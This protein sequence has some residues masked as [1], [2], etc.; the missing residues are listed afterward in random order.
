MHE[1][2]IPLSPQQPD[3]QAPGDSQPLTTIAPLW[4]TTLVI[5]LL[6]G[7]SLLSAWGAHVD[8]HRAAPMSARFGHLTSYAV[9]FVYEWILLAVIVWGIRLLGVPL[10]R[11]LGVRRSGAS[12][13]WM[14]IAIGLGFWFGSLIVLGTAG[15][16]LR[17]ARLHPE[18]VRGIVSK[19]APASPLELLAWLLLSITAGICE[20]LIFRGY[21]QQQF[22]AITRNTGVGIAIAALI[23]GAAHLYEG[24]SGALLIALFGALFGLLAHYR[25]SLRAGM[26]AHAWH[27]A[28]SGFVL[29]FTAHVL[30]RLPH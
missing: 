25:R 26:F 2:G 9:T 4:H 7:I 10:R 29:Y 6:L 8:A 3:T 30:H 15:A 16:L 28:L 18:D 27:D 19:L 1:P 13:F 21:L 14:D 22:S 5:V 23:F 24:V 17:V 20:E 11:L 12:E